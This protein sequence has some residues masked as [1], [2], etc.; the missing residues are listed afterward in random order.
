MKWLVTPR[1]SNAAQAIRVHPC[2]ESLFLSDLCTRQ[3]EVAPLSRHIL[4]NASGGH[5]VEEKS[6]RL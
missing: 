1:V 4:I 5:H 3:A 2:L 6:F